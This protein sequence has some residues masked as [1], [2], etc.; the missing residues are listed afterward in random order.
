M[1]NPNM[2]LQEELIIGFIPRADRWYI[3]VRFGDRIYYVINWNHI[4][5]L[6][7]TLH[8]KIA[9]PKGNKSLVFQPSIFMCYT[10]WHNKQLLSNAFFYQT[11]LV[12]GLTTPLKNMLVKL[13]S[14]SPN[15]RGEHKTCLSCHHLANSGHSQMKYLRFPSISTSPEATWWN[16]LWCV[17]GHHFPPV[18]P[19][20]FRN[21]FTPGVSHKRSK[22]SYFSMADRLKMGQNESEK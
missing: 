15:F 16:L 19:T 1:W 5:S 9:I 8:L 4:P 11:F 21:R 13:G 14:S 12:A 17:L 22:T 7:L 2:N 6:K 18:A 3:A 20:A 10:G